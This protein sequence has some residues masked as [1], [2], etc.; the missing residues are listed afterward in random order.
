MANASVDGGGWLGTLDT[1]TKTRGGRRA[2]DEKR[3][4]EIGEAATNNFRLRYDNAERRDKQPAAANAKSVRRVRTGGTGG[5]GR[6]EDC[7]THRPS[8][9]TFENRT[10]RRDA[11]ACHP[12]A[13]DRNHSNV[14]GLVIRRRT[15]ILR[16]S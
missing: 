2:V 5:N 4:R 12:I 8:V 16:P 3:M 14:Y 1:R 9:A 7:P 15:I 13:A 11:C 10:D 6:R